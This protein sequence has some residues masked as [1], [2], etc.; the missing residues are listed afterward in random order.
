MPFNFIDNLLLPSYIDF[1]RRETAA[2][3]SYHAPL[4]NRSVTLSRMDS[5]FYTNSFARGFMSNKIK[6]AVAL[7]SVVFASG[8][9]A[10]QGQTSAPTL[11]IVTEDVNLPSEL[12]YGGTKVKPVRLRP[13][14]N[15]R[16]TIDD[17]DFFVQQQYVDFLN[18]M[19]DSGGFTDWN[20]VLNNCGAAKGGL[21]SPTGCDRVHV[22][23]G[24]FRSTEFGERGFWVYRF[25]D[26][27]LG[28]L[29]K[30]GEFVPDMR[31]VSGNL[32]ATQLEANRVAFVNEVMARPE[33]TAK[34]AG[35]TGGALMSKLEE[36]AGVTIGEPLR[37]SLVAKSPG[38]IVRG[39]IESQAVWDKFFYR[40]F[41]AMQYFGYLRRDPEL[42]GYN[43]WVRVL[44]SGDAPTGIQPGDY[45]HLI[46]GF[47]YSGEYRDRF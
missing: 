28:R 12:F 27:A 47:I 36:T 43:D 9:V 41:V 31:K 25:Y 2:I 1:G 21:G 13:G 35:L 17:N 40:G 32:T 29:A 3:A 5:R 15:Q 7:L 16:I 11:K 37:S 10:V 24:F 19:P 38:E 4:N 14:T 46:F 6:L 20:N 30:Y 34:Y 8:G 44:T 18:R 23:S 26:A 33:F 42:A 45:R 22:S 39:F